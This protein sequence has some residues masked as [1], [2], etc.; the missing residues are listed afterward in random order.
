MSAPE[1]RR[2]WA[3]LIVAILGLAGLVW[4]AFAQVHLDH[5]ARSS[6]ETSLDLRAQV[7]GT[8]ADLQRLRVQLLEQGIKPVVG[9]PVTVQVPP[10]QRGAPG[11]PGEPGLRGP[12]GPAGT[13]GPPGAVGTAGDPGA[14]GAP[15]AQGE[16][17]PPGKE[18][19]AGPAGPAGDPGPAGPAGPAGASPTTVY[20]TPDPTGGPW[21]CTTSPAPPNA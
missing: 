9:P 13:P 10:G 5:K 11:P 17:G 6:Q 21:S 3:L 12:R 20:C 1:R 18:G 4:T 14:A 16:P 15:G 8:Q 19:A 7:A 2:W